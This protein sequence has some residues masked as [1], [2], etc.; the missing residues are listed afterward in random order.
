MARVIFHI[1][2][3]IRKII[4]LFVS[5]SPR[6]S[7]AQAGEDAILKFLFDSRHILRPSYL[8]L[9]TNKPDEANNTFLFYQNGAVGVCVEADVTL[10]DRIKKVR[11]RDRVILAGV[12]AQDAGVA[13]F[14]VFDEPSL[15]TFSK[16]EA[17]V[18]Q[19]SEKFRI[20]QIVDVPLVTINK[21]LADN[22]SSTPELL[23][24][25]I[26]GLDLEVLMSLDYTKYPIPVICVETCEYS[27]SHFKPK[28]TAIADFLSSKGYFVYGDTYINTIFVSRK[29]FSEESI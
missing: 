16:A 26:E 9:G 10:I 25:D 23:S 21:L 18:R 4:F 13:P 8:E 11:P 22:F 15:N 1:K 7:Y 19:S 29:W 17:M 28:N 2:R 20:E 5:E 6:G 3:A 14:Y 24:I 12:S 27:E